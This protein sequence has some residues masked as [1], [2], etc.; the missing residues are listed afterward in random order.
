M[1]EIEAIAGVQGGYVTRGQLVRM[2][3]RDRTIASAVRR[4]H[5]R[6]IRYGTY[7]PAATYDR[8][9]P[10]DRHAVAVRAV[11][12]KLGDS[13]AA[14]GVSAAVL[15]RDPDFGLDLSEVNVTRLGTLS[16]RREAGVRYRRGG[17]LP[18]DLTRID[19][20][21]VTGPTRTCIEIGADVGVEAA[22]VQVS[23][24]L[25]SEHI[26]KDDLA[27]LV[28]ARYLRW[29]DLATFRTAVEIADG[30]CESP[31]EARSLF[32]FFKHGVPRP[33]LQRTL[34]L[35]TGALARVDFD[36][37]GVRHVG[38][39]DGLVKYGR[40]NP[41]STDVGQVLTDEKE[42]EDR[43]RDLDYGVSRWIWREL[44][45]PAAVRTAARIRAAIERSRR[46]FVLAVAGGAARR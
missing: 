41:Y 13:V 5:L 39:F 20:R 12:D 42:R 29:P 24:L 1:D 27:A 18:E 45:E 38:E 40:R 36:W 34:T 7:A 15:R 10:R 25:A 44:R 21:L 11:L 19:G 30:R 6:K 8:L 35:E 4:G 31:G 32:L 17:I 26:A 33:D 43:I 22:T 2:G 23:N 9:D 3:I 28:D 14:C 37:V 16:G 46:T